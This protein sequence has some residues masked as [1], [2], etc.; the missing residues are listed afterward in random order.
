MKTH[1]NARTLFVLLNPPAMFQGVD[2]ASS[3][4]RCVVERHLKSVDQLTR[5]PGPQEVYG[6]G[7][8]GAHSALGRSIGIH[9]DTMSVDVFGALYAAWK[10]MVDIDTGGFLTRAS[11]LAII[12]SGDTIDADSVIDAVAYHIRPAST[13]ELPTTNALRSFVFIGDSITNTMTRDLAKEILMR[14]RAQESA[15]QSIDTYGP[16]ARH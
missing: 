9:A 14:Y 11:I 6:S 16:V 1:E 5:E 7:P 8:P 4:F 3:T 2:G 12:L 15:V 10:K 13:E